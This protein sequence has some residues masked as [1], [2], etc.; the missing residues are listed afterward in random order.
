MV[1]AISSG[2]RGRL[3][4][5]LLLCLAAIS[6][7]GCLGSSEEA[8][9]GP[10]S[11]GDGGGAAADAGTDGSVPNHDGGPV[12]S[13][14]GPGP[15]G[16]AGLENDGGVDPMPGGCAGRVFCDDFETH[17]AGRT[18]KAPLE[19]EIDN[20]SSV[21][22]VDDR[23][24]SGARSVKV[25]ASGGFVS[26]RAMMALNLAPFFPRRAGFYGRV[27]FFAPAAPR[28][29][30][31]AIIQGSGR[32]EGTTNRATLGYGGGSG[33]V[34]WAN[35]GGS[36]GGLCGDCWL[37]STTAIPVGRWA[38]LEWYFDAENQETRLY[39]DGEE[40]ADV[41]ATPG[42]DYSAAGT[43]GTWTAPTFDKVTLG[44]ESYILDV[45]GGAGDQVAYFDDLALDEDR[46]GCPN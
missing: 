8:S 12:G 15:D 18:P 4:V 42:A 35:F 23:A 26:R 44:W 45:I 10:P 32:I 17:E 5:A 28:T 22:V 2:S 11:G 21:T 43:R 3:R 34:I 7:S 6:G 36:G 31:A 37:A 27:M 29:T 25:V 38:C 41:R 19:V 9:V 33:D 24:Y 46:I 39:L 16:D 14:G 20:Q 30:H 13:D 40:V 1:G